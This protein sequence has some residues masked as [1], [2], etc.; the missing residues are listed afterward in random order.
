MNRT[1]KPHRGLTRTMYRRVVIACIG[2]LLCPAAFA[3]GIR[4]KIELP[5]DERQEVRNETVTYESLEYPRFLNPDNLYVDVHGKAPFLVEVAV[6]GPSCTPALQFEEV[7]FDAI[8]PEYPLHR[9]TFSRLYTEDS[10]PGA[11][12]GHRMSLPLEFVDGRRAMTMEEGYDGPPSTYEG[13]WF[14]NVPENWACDVVVR[15]TREPVCAMWAQVTGDVQQTADGGVAYFNAFENG[16]PI[17]TGTIADEGMHQE[18]EG[19]LAMA[20]GMM[21]LAE[22]MGYEVPDPDPDA[23]EDENL[24][25]PSA[26]GHTQAM[27]DELFAEGGDTFG[28]TLADVN[29]EAKSGDYHETDSI[30]LF[31]AAALFAGSFTLEA[32]APGG[33]EFN[34]GPAG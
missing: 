23:E 16:V 18:L 10:E 19:F 26:Y 24:G 33:V 8:H 29:T 4:V 9:P 20:E 25:S 12:F 7:G 15:V 17:T 2:L 28:L 30:H 31:Q 11:L 1:A 5:E 21:E 32:S 3:Q 27:R 34:M 6:G 14:R 13:E 22:E